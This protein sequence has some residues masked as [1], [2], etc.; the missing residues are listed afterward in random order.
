MDMWRG[1]KYYT[2]GQV[3]ILFREKAFIGYIQIAADK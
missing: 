2:K 1:K 3:K